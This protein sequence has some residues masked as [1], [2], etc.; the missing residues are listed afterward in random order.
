M[1]RFIVLVVVG[2]V[3]AWPG[4]AE[5]EAGSSGAGG[6]TTA[7]A[8]FVVGTSVVNINPAVTTYA[9][10]FGASPPIP[11]GKVIGDPLS[12]RA[13]Y[14]SNGHHAIELETVDSQGEF[15]AYQEGANYGITYARVMAA[16]DINAAH[17]GPMMSSADIIIQATHG[18]A[19]PTL[20][21]LWGPVPVPYLEQV[22]QAQIEALVDA[23]Q[24]TQPAEIEVGSADATALDDVTL[25][26]YD[27]YPGW[28]GDPLLAVLRAVN[29]GTGATIAT[30]ATIPAHPDIVCG[31]CLGQL[32]ADYPGVVR[33]ALE[34]Q[35]GGVAMVGPGTLG[36]EE[37]PV[38][39][40]GIDDMELLAVQ[41]TNLVDVALSGAC[42]LTSNELEAKQSFIR[43]PGTNAALLALVEA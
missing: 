29:P 30:Y 19:V 11:P 2:A 18:H 22:T 9:A 40:T 13:M 42:F 20:Q 10:G 7:P 32:N 14:I 12:V 15:A 3:L 25:A 5:G 38:Q 41:A 16:S 31:A 36:R 17:T 24:S 39:A 4:I 35:F 28:V 23:A 1:R 6:A 21:G 33:S 8:Q 43:F 34:A 27:A 26:Q 37:T